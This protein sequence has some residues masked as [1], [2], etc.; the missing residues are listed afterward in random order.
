MSNRRIE[1]AV[2]NSI[3]KR[4]FE[5]NCEITP[6]KL[7]KLM[8]F[9]YKEYLQKTG[10]ALFDERFEVWK[11]GPVVKSVY[12]E[13]RRFTANPI[14]SYAKSY[15]EEKAQVIAR[16]EGQFYETLDI[17]W[18]KYYGLNAIT[19]SEITHVEGGA[20]KKALERKEL[21]LSDNDI[22]QEGWYDEWLKE[23]EKFQH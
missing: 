18:K 23:E 5:E 9:T 1:L 4:A 14:T 21:H 12:N 13:F 16:K 3:L 17:I 10:T 2:A 20:W 19:L 7:Q 15:A 8:Y 22:I 11:L 6:L